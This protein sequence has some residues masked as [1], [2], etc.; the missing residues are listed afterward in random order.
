MLSG[1]SGEN[2]TESVTGV[3]KEINGYKK[4]KYTDVTDAVEN[5]EHTHYG[6]YADIGKVLDRFTTDELIRHL[7]ENEPGGEGSLRNYVESQITEAQ[8]NRERYRPEY[9]NVTDVK[10]NIETESEYEEISSPR[11]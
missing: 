5:R 9:E 11:L 6:A 7:R 3:S 1:I 10:S 2:V 4:E 8:I